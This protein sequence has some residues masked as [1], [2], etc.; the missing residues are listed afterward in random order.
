[1]SSVQFVLNLVLLVLLGVW[2]VRRRLTYGVSVI[3]N[4]TEIMVANVMR[5]QST[6]EP[7]DVEDLLEEDGVERRGVRYFRVRPQG[8]VQFRARLVGNAKSRL[9]VLKYSDANC[10]IVRQ[11]L[12]DDMDEMHVRN[13]DRALHIDA[14]VALFFIPND[15]EIEAE[16]ILQLADAWRRRKVY[17]SRTLSL[18]RFVDC[19]NCLRDWDFRGAY[20]ALWEREHKA[21]A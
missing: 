1:M 5:E 17:R 16:Q 2:Y 3:S 6:D 13:V 18:P 19:W 8:R 4:D 11:K 21:R 20:D 9:G 12:N 10:I 15:A 14:C 7:D